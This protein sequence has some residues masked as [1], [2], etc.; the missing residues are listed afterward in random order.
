MYVLCIFHRTRITIS[1]E[2]VRDM[3][4]WYFNPY[5]LHE[6]LPS[7]CMRKTPAWKTCTVV[8][9]NCFVSNP[10]TWHTRT[11]ALWELHKI[12]PAGKK[13]KSFNAPASKASVN[14]LN[15]HTA[16]ELQNNA[17]TNGFQ[18]LHYV[19]LWEYL[20][21]RDANCILKNNPFDGVCAGRGCQW[22]VVNVVLVSGVWQEVLQDERI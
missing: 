16:A 20:A 5:L 14:V 12:Q 9:G 18:S 8:L 7:Q 11:V 2:S 1:A 10:S 17:F 6:S 19:N 22:S 4:K 3:E 13:T 21:F 15:W